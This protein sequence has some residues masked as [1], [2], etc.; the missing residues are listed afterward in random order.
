M[1]ARA[2][3]TRGETVLS[4]LVL[5]GVVLGS[6]LLQP[7]AGDRERL[8][9]LVASV[10]Q[11]FE[12]KSLG[13]IADHLAPD[14][15]DTGGL[16]RADVVKIVPRVMRNTKQIEVTINDQSIE[17]TLRA[18]TGHFDVIVDLDEGGGSVITLRRHLE[19]TFEKRRQG[20]LGL[21]RT[22]WLVTSVDG[23]GLHRDCEAL[24]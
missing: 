2:A 9:E 21:W 8:E 10:E 22:K 24:F 17:V 18:A 15:S 13:K 4:L 5:C 20:P 7:H 12:T 23:H 11:G 1:Y 16:S 6:W 3:D 19:V 14:Y